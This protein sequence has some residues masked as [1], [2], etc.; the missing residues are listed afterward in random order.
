MPCRPNS[1][2]SCRCTIWPG[3]IPCELPRHL[4]GSGCSRPR[5]RVRIA[6][7]PRARRKSSILRYAIENNPHDGQARLQLG[8]LLGNLGRIGEAVPLWKEAAELGAG[9]IAWRNLGLVAAVD[10]D[11]QRAEE[12]FRRAIDARPDDQTL[13]RDLAEILVADQRRG[14]AIALLEAMPLQGQRRAELT[15]LLAES[16]VAEKRYEQC[17][18]LLE[19]LAYFVNWEGQ[20]ITW[21]LFNQAHIERGRQR[22]E[23]GDA[24]GAL[25]DFDAALTYPAN[26]NVGRSNQPLEA[27]AQFWRGQALQDA[28]STGRIPRGMAGRSRRSR[29]RRRT[30]RVS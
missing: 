18:E 24:T 8:C 9:S 27:P 25:A 20:D 13:Y 5:R 14:D 16:Y 26:L 28:E 6:Y 11:V 29:R 17:I 4:H 30:E 3:W 12:C 2:V 1:A 15:V 23:N 7:S 21:R 22:L 19:S 10:G